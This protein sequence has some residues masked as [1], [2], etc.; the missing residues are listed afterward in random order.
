MSRARA[1]SLEDLSEAELADRWGDVKAKGET[2]E[3]A[4]EALK[5][6]FDRRKLDYARGLRFRVTKDTSVQQRFDVAAARTALG[7]EAAKYLKPQ[8]RTSWLVRPIEA[9]A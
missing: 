9:E 3:Q 5:A 1:V 4:I 2:A 8:S 6:E 7:A